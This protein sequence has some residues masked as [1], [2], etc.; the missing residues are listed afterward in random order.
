MKALRCR[1]AN[2]S[3]FHAE[4]FEYSMNKWC[5]LLFMYEILHEKIALKYPEEAY[6]HDTTLLNGTEIK[7]R[8]IETLT[9]IV[10]A[11]KPAIEKPKENAMEVKVH[12]VSNCLIWIGRTQTSN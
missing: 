7:K 11:W 3:A 5:I 1:L 6:A 10:R 8:H 2:L 12:F 9:K 4:Y